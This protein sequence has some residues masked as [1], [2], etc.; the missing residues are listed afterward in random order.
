MNFHA[1]T[2]PGPKEGDFKI[3]GEARGFQNLSRDLAKVNAF[4]IFS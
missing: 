1:L 2:S 3:E 4:K